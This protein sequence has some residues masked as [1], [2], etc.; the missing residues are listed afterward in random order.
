VPSLPLRDYMSVSVL[1]V[2]ADAALQ[3][4]AEKMSE[5][6]VS[7]AVVC[8]A[9]GQPLGVVSERDLTRA[10]AHHRESADTPLVTT[11]M[12]QGVWTMTENES[13]DCAARTMRE[14][15]IRR[16]VIVD[17]SNKVAG[18]VT[19]S[20]ML[21]A[22]ACEIEL[23]KLRLEERVAERTRELRALNTRLESLSRIDPLMGIGN[24]RAMDDELSRMEERVRRYLRP[25]SVALVD[26]DY[27]KKF[28]AHYGHG[29]GDE[30]LKKVASTIVEA[31]RSADSVFRYGGEELLMIFPESRQ[32]GAKI[33]A[34][35]VCSAVAELELAHQ[36]SP[37]G[38]LTISVGVAQENMVAPDW[39][40]TVA[41]ADVA[42]YC[43]KNAGRNRIAEDA[44]QLPASVEVAASQARYGPTGEH[45][46]PALS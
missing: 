38:H 41:R 28:N 16:L 6:R 22:H 4:V 19:Q 2:T 14:R 5:A 34:Q 24:R 9:D 43:A 39:V 32:F 33:A 8:A 18:I 7:C 37:F 44:S 15:G 45:I 26:I 31:I 36:E 17:A 1:S 35:N 29:A 27:F 46:G 11:A 13:C 30:A 23:Q 40:K 3:Q 12:S 42:L 21:R 20:D 10:Y 25:Y